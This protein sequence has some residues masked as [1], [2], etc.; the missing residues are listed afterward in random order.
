MKHLYL[1]LLFLGCVRVAVGQEDPLYAQYLN[2]PLLINP[3]YTG[4]NDNFNGSIAYRKQ[5]SGFDGNP[6]TLNIS[7]HSSFH[8]NKMGLGFLLVQDKLGATC[9]TEAYATYAYRLKLN[10]TTL[11]FGLQGGLINYNSN[12]N[13]LNAYDPNDPAFTNGQ[14]VTK[15]SVGAGIILNSEKFFIGLSVPRM[16]ETTAMLTNDSTSQSTEAILYDQHYYM[17]AAYVFYLSERVRLKPS[18]LVKAVQGAPLS[19]D[20]NVSINL[21]EK[22]TVGLYTR[23]LNTCGLLTQ[24]RFATAYRFGYTFEIPLNNS[25]GTRFTTHELTFGFNMAILKAHSSSYTNF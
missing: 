20:Y 16:L 11:S 10:A 17:T 2:N 22:Y 7:G 23:N 18:V 6:T 21:D 15:P 5:W 19:V 1:A 4:L 25:V 12:N 3:A 9:N 14:N 13:Q 24:L 8:K